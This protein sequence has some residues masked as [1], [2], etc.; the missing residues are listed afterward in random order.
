MKTIHLPLMLENY[1]GSFPIVTNLKINDI[2]Y[3]GPPAVCE[4]MIVKSL[5][6]DLSNFVINTDK[7]ILV[8][9]SITRVNRKG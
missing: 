3:I 2:L 4:E 6:K 5:K 7:A 1:Y 8:A 9:N